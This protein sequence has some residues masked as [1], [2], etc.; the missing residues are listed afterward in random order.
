MRV[1]LTS[2]PG[3]APG[4]TSVSSRGFPGHLSCRAACWQNSPCHSVSQVYYL[5]FGALVQESGVRRKVFVRG[6]PLGLFGPAGCSGAGTTLGTRRWQ[7]QGGNQV[8]SWYHR[9]LAEVT[10]GPWPRLLSHSQGPEPGQLCGGHY[11][12]FVESGSPLGVP[13]PSQALGRRVWESSCLTASWAEGTRIFSLPGPHVVRGTALPCPV[14][15]LSPLLGLLP[16]SRP[17]LGDWA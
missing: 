16:H 14:L 9:P 15:I 12:P 10:S 4:G 7:G 1:S 6:P 13:A 5:H 17:L 8:S 11:R 3:L 2:S